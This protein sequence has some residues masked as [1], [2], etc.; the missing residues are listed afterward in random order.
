MKKYAKPTVLEFGDAA[1]VTKGGTVPQVL[2]ALEPGDNF[3]VPVE[4]EPPAPSVS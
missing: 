4:P 2:D 3:G 1:R